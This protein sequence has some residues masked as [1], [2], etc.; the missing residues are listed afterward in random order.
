MAIFGPSKKE[1]WKQLADDIRADCFKGSRSRKLRVEYRYRNWTIVLDTFTVSTGRSNT[2]YT[3]MRAPYKRMNDVVFKLYR[4][5]I[6]SWIGRLFGMPLVYV[7]DD[8]FNDEYILKGN[9]ET[10][11]KEIFQNQNIT[12]KIRKQ[13]RLFLKTVSYSSIT[14]SD[15]SE[16]YFRKNGVIKDPDKL[17]NLFDLFSEML[18]EFVKQRIASEQKPKKKL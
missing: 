13:K 16:L 5:N 15:E 2:T 10:A 12:D 9:D 7:Y 3:R 14:E 18:D 11:I 6:F 8:S 4:K 17:R 1:V